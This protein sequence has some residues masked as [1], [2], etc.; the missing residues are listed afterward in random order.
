M[1]KIVKLKF[2]ILTGHQEHV[3]VNAEPCES[4]GVLLLSFIQHSIRARILT[5]ANLRILNILEEKQD[6]SIS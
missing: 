1:N 4:T 5:I 3:C 2:C 6:A